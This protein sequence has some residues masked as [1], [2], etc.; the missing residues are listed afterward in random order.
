LIKITFNTFKILN[1]YIS[2]KIKLFIYLISSVMTI[3]SIF[4]NFNIRIHSIIIKYKTKT[5]PPLLSFLSL[6]LSWS[7]DGH[8]LTPCL[9]QKSFPSLVHLILIVPFFFLL[10]FNLPQFHSFINSNFKPNKLSIPT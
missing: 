4:F 3:F 5:S 2:F 10:H 6:P 9:L 7:M 8:G 1:K